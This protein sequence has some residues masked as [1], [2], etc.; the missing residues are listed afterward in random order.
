MNSSATLIVLKDRDV[1]LPK[2]KNILSK[3]TIE[4]NI[5][6]RENLI[7][8]QTST[9]LIE[10][11]LIND[12]LLSHLDEHILKSSGHHNQDKKLVFEDQ[13]TTGSRTVSNLVQQW[14][15][16]DIENLQDIVAITEFE[17]QI[18][19]SHKN[20]RKNSKTFTNP[21][22]YFLKSYVFPY[23][24]SQLPNIKLPIFFQISIYQ[25]ND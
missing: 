17:P 20:M 14:N 8:P 5:S 12:K 10:S 11:P 24:I 23:C 13:I 15:E 25:T 16:G 2:Q 18:I 7:S 3:I 19:N 4:K 1:S 22:T 21:G 9:N 6:S